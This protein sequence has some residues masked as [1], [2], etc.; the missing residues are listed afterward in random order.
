M[1][2]VQAELVSF[3]VINNSCIIHDNEQPRSQAGDEAIDEHCLVRVATIKTGIWYIYG[4]TVA[5]ARQNRILQV[6]VQL[7]HYS[8]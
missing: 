2:P 8:G 3:N 5:P 7:R 1:Y 6:W 4:S